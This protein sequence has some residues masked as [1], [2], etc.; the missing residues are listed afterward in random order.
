MCFTLGVAGHL[1]NFSFIAVTHALTW[2][3]G[4][5]GPLTDRAFVGFATSDFF[6]PALGI[7][8]QLDSKTGKCTPKSCNLDLRLQ[9]INCVSSLTAAVPPLQCELNMFS[10]A[11]FF[12]AA[13]FHQTQDSLSQL[14]QTS[15]QAG[16]CLNHINMRQQYLPPLLLPTSNCLF[17]PAIK[18]T[19]H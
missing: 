1:S 4:I 3:F 6:F 16:V 18:N 15:Y 19:S 5:R 17:I 11:F 8:C 9:M 2:T 7:H 12:R 14:D 13:K 10:K